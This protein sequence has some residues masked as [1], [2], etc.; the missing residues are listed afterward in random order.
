MNAIIY[1]TNQL[2]KDETFIQRAC[3]A[4]LVFIF[5]SAVSYGYMINAT[6]GNIV[7]RQK[8]QTGIAAISA[9]LAMLET[10]HLDLKNRIDPSLAASLG[11]VAV[12]E[13]RFVTYN[14]SQSLSLNVSR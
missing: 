4:V 1:H 3:F 13:P 6:I 7:A 5:C 14:Q 9:E 11:F 10:K 12:A 8:A 2:T